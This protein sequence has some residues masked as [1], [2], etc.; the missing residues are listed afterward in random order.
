MIGA[1]E[2]AAIL[3]RQSELM[4]DEH[5]FKKMKLEE[6]T[7]AK[8]RILTEEKEER[9]KVFKESEDL[10][11]QY[12]KLLFDKKIALMNKMMEEIEVIYYVLYKGKTHKEINVFLVVELLRR[13]GGN[14]DVRRLKKQ[15]VFCVFF[16]TVKYKLPQFLQNKDNPTALFTNDKF[17]FF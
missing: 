17:V 7:A 5:V 4:E 15:L 6:E 10:N 1:E 11:R 9:M 12:A 2:A 13:G 14:L 16:Y 8:I 3:K